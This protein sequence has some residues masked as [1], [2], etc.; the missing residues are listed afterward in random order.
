LGPPPPP[1]PPQLPP[2]ARPHTCTRTTTL[3]GL[4]LPYIPHQR[5]VGACLH[6]APAQIWW[7]VMG[8]PAQILPYPGCTGGPWERMDCTNKDGSPLIPRKQCAAHIWPEVWRSEGDG[9]KY[10]EYVLGKE[11]VN[12]AGTKQSTPPSFAHM[13]CGTCLRV[14]CGTCDTWKC[15]R[16]YDAF[17]RAQ[18]KQAPTRPTTHTHTI[19]A[20]TCTH[21]DARALGRLSARRTTCRYCG[22]TR[23]KW[24]LHQ[25][26]DLRQV[27][28]PQRDR[29]IGM[30]R[31]A[32]AKP[33][34]LA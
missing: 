10:N 16:L 28:R 25:R 1:P 11:T 9:A 7:Q 27:V 21:T 24:H 5:G 15:P 31:R 3:P 30:P 23:P 22:S 34:A 29:C 13:T 4:L 8:W 32:V 33:T 14:T 2:H 12:S 17:A 19:S 18:L 20:H 6:G 26:V